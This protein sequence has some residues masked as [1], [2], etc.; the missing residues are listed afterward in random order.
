MTDF[1]GVGAGA[2][3]DFGKLVGKCRGEHHFANVVQ[4]SDNV[5]H[6][7]VDGERGGAQDLARHD[8]RADAVFPQFAPREAEL[9]FA[10]ALHVLDHRRGHRQFTY[11]P[12]AEKEH[13]LLDVVDL[14][15]KAE[16]YAVDHAQE[17]GR[18]RGVAADDLGDLR[19]VAALGVDDALKVLVDALQGG[20]FGAR[21]DAPPDFIVRVRCPV[22]GGREWVGAG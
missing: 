13:R 9:G 14:G 22:N 3:G 1:G 2:H 17:A 11:L 6:V 4:Q 15:A 10:D 16:K 18:E 21:V 12:D 19:R 5:V 20:E 7:V 8:A